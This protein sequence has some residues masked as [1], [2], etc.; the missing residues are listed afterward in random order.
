MSR[1]ERIG[2]ATL[3]LGD[4]RDVLPSLGHV[5]AVVTDPPYGI[6]MD[7]GKIGRATY[8]KRDWDQ[9]RPAWLPSLI[10]RLYLRQTVPAIVWGGNYLADLLPAAGKWLVWDKRNDPTSFADCEMAWT[11][12]AGSTRLFRWLWSGPYMQEK[13]DRHHPTQKP[14]ALMEWCLGQLP[15][16]ARSVVDPFM[17]SGT[18]GV[19]CAKRGYRFIGIELAESYFDIACRRIEEATRQGD[20][21]RD[22]EPKPQQLA[23][24]A[25]WESQDSAGSFNAAI[26]AIKEE[27]HSGRAPIPDAGYFERARK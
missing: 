2:E 26:S 12:L 8:E 14:R 18:T 6:G 4:C 17:G 11:N 23:L 1:V 9:Q 3:Y 27:V 19:A 21:L 25:D 7:G 13:E 10:E 20:L 5:D 24:P 22:V 16:S 15:D